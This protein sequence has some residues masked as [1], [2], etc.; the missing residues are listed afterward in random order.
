MF[1]K[2]TEFYFSYIGS[3]IHNYTFVFPSVTTM[4]MRM[5]SKTFVIT[6]SSPLMLRQGV[7]SC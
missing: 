5:V 6:I 4:E 2:S 1:G 3:Q 7:P